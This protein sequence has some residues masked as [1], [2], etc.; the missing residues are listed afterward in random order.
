MPPATILFLSD[1]TQELD[2]AAGAG[3]RAGLVMRPGNAPV[4]AG[5]AHPVV[6]DFRQVNGLLF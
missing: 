6:T 2:A 1:V 3:M 4:P 5:H